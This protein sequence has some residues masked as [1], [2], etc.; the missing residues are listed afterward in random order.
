MEKIKHIVKKKLLNIV[1]LIPYGHDFYLLLTKTRSGISYRG[2]FESLEEARKGVAASL[3]SDYDAINANKAATS[4]KEQQSLDNWF[5][6][7]DYPLLYWLSKLITTQNSVLELGG[8]VGHFFY[9]IKKYESFSE[10]LKWRIAELPE[11]VKLG[12]KFAKDRM[13][14]RLSFVESKEI[15][16]VEPVDIFVTAG[17]LQYMGMTI[18]EILETLT[19]LPKHVLIHNL[20][21][22][23][24]RAFWTLQNLNLCEVPY[25][26]YSK[27]DLIRSMKDLGYHRVAEW[28]KPREIEIPFHRMLKIEGYLGFY[29][30]KKI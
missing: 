20:P 25:R 12:R 15:G 27:R 22:H 18:S 23:E 8:S 2:I 1:D 5:H 11:A 7:H 14:T 10:H 28:C 16:T 6:D 17:T 13:E 30:L 9:S 21:T 19:D 24:Q 4:E 29:F 3:S 26:V